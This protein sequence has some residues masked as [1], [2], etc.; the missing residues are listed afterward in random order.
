MSNDDNE[1]ER[2]DVVERDYDE[3]GGAGG[4]DDG[5]AEGAKGD[6][7]LMERLQLEEKNSYAQFGSTSSQE[8]N[9]DHAANNHS[10]QETSYPFAPD[11]TP[12]E[13]SAHL[14]RLAK[15]K[16]K[17][18]K[19]GDC[20]KTFSTTGNLNV[21]YRAIHGGQVGPPFVNM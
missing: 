16:K 6:L 15:P 4:D 20:G 9:F 2:R 14:H 17:T 10:S 21:H 5:G 7:T 13:V 8:Y 19:C 1:E 11:A 3:G 18:H 12:E